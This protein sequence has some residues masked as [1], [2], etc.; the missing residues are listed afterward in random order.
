MNN[1]IRT[2]LLVFC[3]AVALC[4]QNDGEL[5]FEGGVVMY[6]G[7]YL[8]VHRTGVMES[9]N[10]FNGA[11]FKIGLD[12]RHHLRGQWKKYDGSHSSA[13][14][15][16]YENEFKGWIMSL[17]YEY[18]YKIWKIFSGHIG[19][20]YMYHQ[21]RVES[22]QTSIYEPRGPHYSNEL[23]HEYGA[24]MPIGLNIELFERIRLS[25]EVYFFISNTLYKEELSGKKWRDPQEFEFQGKGVLTLGIRI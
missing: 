2:V 15:G 8:P 22:V 9:H 23:R 4:G 14:E 6:S 11:Y 18:E 12:K 24:R 16:T 19:W 7:I 25:A 20:E 1:L 5:K 21:L 10:Q 17:G 3:S 13:Y